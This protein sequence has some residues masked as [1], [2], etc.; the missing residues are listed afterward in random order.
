MITTTSKC[1]SFIVD[2]FDTMKQIQNCFDQHRTYNPENCY[3]CPFWMSIA[4]YVL[5]M[6]YV[7]LG[8]QHLQ[9]KIVKPYLIKSSA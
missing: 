7:S 5:C 6:T 9:M 8:L 2:V 3:H 1:K 4:R